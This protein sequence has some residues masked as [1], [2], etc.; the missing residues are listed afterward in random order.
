[1]PCRNVSIILEKIKLEIDY[2]REYF[3]LFI[4]EPFLP[5]YRNRYSESFT[6]V[7]PAFFLTGLH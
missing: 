3:F 4:F 2:Y 5:N 1:M 7:V 6:E